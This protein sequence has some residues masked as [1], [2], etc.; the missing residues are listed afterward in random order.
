[1]REPAADHPQPVRADL[2]LWAARFFKTRRLSR[3]AI[4]GGRVELN[5]GTCKPSKTVKVGDVLRVTRGVERFEVEVLDLS[6][7]RGPASAAQALY[8]ESAASVA[9]REAQRE[10]QRLLGAAGPAHRPDKQARRNLRR[11]K[12]GG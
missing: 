5:D 7:K 4:D 8:R 12:H 3:E 10:Q 2:W 6:D 11:L 1:M 9:A